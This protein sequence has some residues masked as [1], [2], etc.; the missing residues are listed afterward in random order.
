MIGRGGG[1][2]G[3]RLLLVSV[4]VLI[5]APPTACRMSRALEVQSDSSSVQSWNAFSIYLSGRLGE[6]EDSYQRSVFTIPFTIGKYALRQ[7]HAPPQQTGILFCVSP[8][9]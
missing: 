6:D 7:S 4:T 9:R 5:Q 8:D 3:L 2:G 1:K